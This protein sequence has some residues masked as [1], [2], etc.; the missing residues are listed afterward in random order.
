MAE[1]AGR[2]PPVYTDRPVV[3]KTGLTGR[4]DIR[5]EFTREVG[6][7]A[8]AYLNGEPAPSVA[9]D[10]NGPSL[11]TALREQL[12]LK[13]VPAKAPIEV[14]VIDHAEHPAAN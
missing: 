14:I 4:W 3:D 6:L 9:A 5:L 2:M 1:F 7:A 11:F 10:P 12:G 13:L 8:P